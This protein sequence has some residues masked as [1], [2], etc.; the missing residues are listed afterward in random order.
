MTT[1]QH[2]RASAH[3]KPRT[4]LEKRPKTFEFDDRFACFH[5]FSAYR[6][7][8]CHTLETRSRKNSNRTLH[9]PT[10]SLAT[11]GSGR[12]GGETG[13]ARHRDRTLA[14]TAREFAHHVHLQA[15]GGG[16]VHIWHQ[17]P[18]IALAPVAVAQSEG[19]NYGSRQ[20]F[21]GQV[22]HQ[23]LITG[24]AEPAYQPISADS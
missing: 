9:T 14:G 8:L 17:H 24:E 4:C 15:G 1:V 23:S 11:C 12:A 7:S 5:A 22:I 13:S 19:C 16:K 6:R 18:A 2:F 10:I 20:A 21:L 3:T